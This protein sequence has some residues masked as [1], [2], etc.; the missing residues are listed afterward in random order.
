LSGVVVEAD[1]LREGLV[2]AE[3]VA[4]RVSRRVGRAME[5][6]DLRGAAKLAL[7]DVVRTYDPSRAAFAPY[8]ASRLKWAL[9]DEVRRQTHGRSAAA[10]LMA[11]MASERFAEAFDPEVPVV[12]EADGGAGGEDWQ[13]RF[14]ALLEGHAA[15]LVIGLVKRA[16]GAARPEAEVPSPED[17]AERAEIAAQVRRHVGALPERERTLVERHYFGG[18]PFDLI[19]QDLGISKSWA[20]RLHERAISQLARD[21]RTAR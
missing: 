11:V 1:L 9:Y 14:A 16:D 7:F 19:A 21:L 15:A 5:L 20:S 2:V 4:R 3:A 18:E 10:R 13:A 17:E 8:A 12:G 6:E